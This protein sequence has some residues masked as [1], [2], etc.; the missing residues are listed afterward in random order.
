LQQ[1]QQQQQQQQHRL[2]GIKSSLDH[3]TIPVSSLCTGTLL[4]VSDGL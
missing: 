3:V 4:A 1:Q 2:H